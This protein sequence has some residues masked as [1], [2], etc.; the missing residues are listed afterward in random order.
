MT[1]TPPVDDPFLTALPP[2]LRRVAPPESPWPAALVRAGAQTGLLVDADL[3]PDEVYRP[4][5]EHVAR[6]CEV[7]RTSAGHAVLMPRVLRPIVGGMA[8]DAGAAVTIAVSL[9]RGLAELGETRPCGAWWLGDDGRP[10]FVP[11]MSGPDAT[12]TTADVLRE[13]ASASGLALLA[14]LAEQVCELE[15]RDVADWEERLFALH[16]PGAVSM[17]SA[18][19]PTLRRADAARPR[20]ADRRR[21]LVTEPRGRAAALVAGV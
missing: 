16:V 18:A 12:A 15:P 4:A 17:G 5:G 14:E 11:M 3:L 10:L 19:A 1:D 20:P 7:Y 21:A 9:V 13:A 2:V 6:P 8:S